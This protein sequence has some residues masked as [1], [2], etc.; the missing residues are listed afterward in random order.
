M[1]SEVFFTR[2]NELA[3]SYGKELKDGQAKEWAKLFGWMDERQWDSI[4]TAARE[5][6][7]RFP[8]PAFIY[9][10][11]RE[12][13]FGRRTVGPTTRVYSVEC[14]GTQIVRDAQGREYYQYQCAK[15][16]CRRVFISPE[17]RPKCLTC[18]ED[19]TIALGPYIRRCLSTFVV[20]E[21]ELRVA[22]ENGQ[23][24]H[25]PNH[26]HFGC[27]VVFDPEVILEKG[28]RYDG[29]IYAE[30]LYDPKWTL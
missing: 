27:N 20:T 8:S 25:C 12:K 21:P 4:A 2:L 3:D 29:I 28:E 26:L 7:D 1:D 10:Q 14:P 9:M 24:Y 22:A 19:K 5:S 30:Q 15:S 13:R 23:I 6:L 17:A 18:K 11:V 16:Q